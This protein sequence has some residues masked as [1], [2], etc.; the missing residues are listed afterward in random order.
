MKKTTYVFSAIAPLVFLML[1]S[2]L[3]EFFGLSR[4]YG[5]AMAF[6]SG[7]LFFFL[8]SNVINLADRFV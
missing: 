3:I 6:F 7:S 5:L 1:N 2:F 8:K 4:G